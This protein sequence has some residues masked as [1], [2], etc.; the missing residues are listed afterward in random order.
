MQGISTAKHQHLVDALLQLEKLLSRDFKQDTDRQQ[1]EEL[2]LELEAM[3]N[4]YNKQVN[5]L[6]ELIGDYH[7]LFTKA[8]MQFL[9]PKL[10][11]LRKQA[12]QDTR[13]LPLLAQNIRLV[14]GT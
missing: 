13:I 5:A 3:H 4:S 12:E 7:E 14:Y 11:E 10:K 6:A 1:A 8:K 2:R 9:S